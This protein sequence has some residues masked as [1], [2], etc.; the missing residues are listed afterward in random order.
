MSSVYLLAVV[1]SIFSKRGK[2]SLG[3]LMFCVQ[4]IP[5]DCLFG[6]QVASH[7]T[8]GSK[9]LFGGLWIRGVCLTSKK[10]GGLDQREICCCVLSGISGLLEEPRLY[11][12]GFGTG[13]GHK[14][15]GDAVLRFE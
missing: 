10:K 6:S 1:D 3:N 7:W 14:L 2:G 12:L 15:L 8:G 11:Q 5:R 13:R 9:R 4:Q